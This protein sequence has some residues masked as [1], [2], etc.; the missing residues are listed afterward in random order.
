MPLPIRT[1][2]LEIRPF[3]IA[4]VA[5]VHVAYSDPD[6]G[7]PLAPGGVSRSL[8]D[9]REVV[10]AILRFHEGSEGLGPWAVVELASGSVMGD[11]GLFRCEDAWAYGELELAYRLRKEAWGRGLATEAAAAV[12]RY[13]FEEMDAPRVVADLDAGNAASLRVLEKVGMGIVGRAGDTLRYA[14]ERPAVPPPR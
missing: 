12:L 13:A 5:E 11:C 8:D 2:R 6:V 10:A 7:W 3:T 1:G 9:T 14:K 4:D